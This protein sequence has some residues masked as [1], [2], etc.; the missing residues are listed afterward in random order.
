MYEYTGS[1]QYLKVLHLQMHQN[2]Q[3]KI[4]ESSKKKNLNLLHASNYLHSIYIVFTTT[5]I[6]FTL[7]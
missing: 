1:P 3:K 2:I 4:P 6:A 5:Y 7:Y